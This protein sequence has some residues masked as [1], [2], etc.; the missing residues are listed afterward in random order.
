MNIFQVVKEA[1]S[2]KDA[3][4]FYGIKIGRNRMACCPF[5]SDKHPSMKIDKRFHCFGCGADG[6]VI[7]FVATYF[8]L[9]VK[10][11]AV[12]I[13]Q[14]FSLPFD[15]DYRPPR[16]RAKPQKSEEQIFREIENHCILVLTDYL[17]LLEEWKIKYTPKDPDEDWHPYYCE[18]LKKMDYVKY[19]LDTLHDG[20]VSDRAFLIANYGKKVIEIERRIEKLRS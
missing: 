6:D 17:K 20:S 3:A 10:D 8:G 16:I 7:D 1:V 11:A 5:H 13:C 9:S 2:A 19:L 18:A 4:S 14:D 12:K 15:T